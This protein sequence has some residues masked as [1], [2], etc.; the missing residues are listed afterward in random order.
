DAYEPTTEEVTKDYGTPTTEED[1]T[2]A[3][4]VPDYPSEEEP[5]TITVDDPTQLPDGNTPGTTEVDVTVTYPDGT[6]DHVKVPVTVGEQAQANT[7]NPGYDN[8]TVQPGETVKVPQTGDNTMPDGTQYEID[9]TK[10]PSGWEVIVDHNTGELTVKPSKDAVPGTSIIIPV[11]VTYPDGSTEATSTTVT[12]GDVIDIPAPTVNPVDN[13]DTE[14]T[15]SNGTPG[16][17]IVVTFPDGTIS[18]GEIDIDGNW[19]VDIPEGIDLDKDDVI[20]AVEKDENGNISTPTNVVVGENCDNPS[21]GN[22]AGD[23]E[24]N[25]SSNDNNPGDGESNNSPSNDKLVEEEKNTLTDENATTGSINQSSDLNE[26]SNTANTTDYKDNNED[27][28]LPETGEN[29]SKQG[30][31]FGALFAGLGSLLLFRKRNKKE[32]K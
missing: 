15:G 28:S 23:G 20:T 21:N 18:E 17:T 26:G 3:V 2:G 25:N 13:N 1:V 7:N 31:L 32:E 19:I 12:V 4:T 10:V 29:D 6:E 11:T 22:N 14:V 24:G 8:V 9:E 27:K 16:N 30:T 5:P